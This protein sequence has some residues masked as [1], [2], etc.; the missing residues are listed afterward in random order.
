MT[1]NSGYLRVAACS[2]NV[3]IAS[4]FENAENIVNQMHSKNKDRV[5]IFV[6]PELS[7]TSASCGDLYTDQLL[8]EAST[9]ALGQIVEDTKELDAVGVV[10]MPIEFQKSIFNVAAV[11]YKGEILGLIPKKNCQSGRGF[12]GSRTEISGS[13]TLDG[14]DEI[15]FGNNLNFELN[16]AIF[17]VEFYEDGIL[18]PSKVDFTIVLSA[19]TATI[20]TSQRI[21]DHLVSKSLIENRAFVYASPGFG[22]STTDSVSSGLS[23]IIDEGVVLAQSELYSLIPQTAISEIDIAKK[24]AIR[25]RKY[26]GIDSTSLTIEIDDN[27]LFLVKELHRPL[28]KNPFLPFKENDTIFADEAYSLQVMGLVQRMVHTHTEKVV[29]GVS[30]GLDS[31]LALLVCYK[32]FK[33]LSLPMSN[34][35]GITMPG[36]GTTGRTKTNAHILMEQMGITTLEISIKEACE[37]HFKDINHNVEIQDV[38]YENSQARE[39]TQILMD[40]ANK[41]NAL[42]IG[43]GDLSELALGWATYNGDHMSMYGVN[44]TIPKTMVQYLVRSIALTTADKVLSKSLLDILDTP[45]SPEL[46]PG[47]STGGI[48]QKTEDLVGPYELHDFFIYHMIKYGFRPSLIYTRALLTFKEKYADEEIKHWLKTFYRRFFMQQFK[49]SCSPDGPDVT[50]VSLS[51]RGGWQMASDVTATI[52]LKE[53]ENL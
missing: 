35:I 32:A 37:L 48:S 40:Y 8:L 6:F 11:F 39:R 41:V 50:G 24:Q 51:P 5:A 47:T 18:P 31:T 16:G 23:A 42:V 34:I 44:S 22:E 30:G 36:F 12:I 53:I 27:D 10:G 46:K 43:T 25:N 49:R 4:C 3:K 21:I 14:I 38:T 29:V 19:E 26:S 28:Q 52:W 2:P 20:G 17:N 7:I 13:I 33:V 45:I 15:A 1:L 9:Q